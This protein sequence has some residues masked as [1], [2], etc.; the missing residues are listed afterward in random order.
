MI[1]FTNFLYIFIDLTCFHHGSRPP[2]SD[3]WPPYQCNYFVSMLYTFYQK[4]KGPSPCMAMHQILHRKVIP[5]RC[6]LFLYLPQS[7]R[8]QTLILWQQKVGYGLCP[9]QKESF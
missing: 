4:H 5:R 6:G 2:H 9:N 3:I 8:L 7:L 1:D